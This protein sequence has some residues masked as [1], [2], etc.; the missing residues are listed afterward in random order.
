MRAKSWLVVGVTLLS[1]TV[2]AGVGIFWWNDAEW[3][4]VGKEAAGAE[5]GANPQ[6]VTPP[7]PVTTAKVRLGDAA[8]V[9]RVTGELVASRRFTV[10]APVAGTLLRLPARTGDRLRRGDL[11]GEIDAAPYALAVREAEAA[12]AV[13]AAEVRAAAARAEVA[14]RG[15]DRLSRLAPEL[16]SEAAIDRVEAEA[17]AREGELAV[18]GAR[19]K[20]AE[21]ARDAA[22]FN[23]R[24][25]RLMV[26][27]Q[28][29]DA[30]RAAVEPAA[31]PQAAEQVYTVVER[32]AEAGDRVGVGGGVVRLARTDPLTAELRGDPALAG[33]LAPGDMV[34]IR[35]DGGGTLPEASV[36]A[37]APVLDR[38]TRR[39]LIEASVP[40][41]QGLLK[42][43]AF[44]TAEVTT[45]RAADVLLVPADALVEPTDG[46]GPRIYRFT[47]G[48]A[49]AV[50][51]RRGLPG[52][53][54]DGETRPLVEV[55]S[56]DGRTLRA[57]DEIVV[58]G[59][60]LVSDGA[61][62]RRGSLGEHPPQPE[63]TP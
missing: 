28:A 24:R 26:D 59:A 40:N 10:A 56:I 12:V 18:A 60:H 44:I 52:V 16:R 21:A 50:T 7:L 32:L 53:L 17:A 8:E 41:P 61:L 42:P 9:T 58:L 34:T 31:A 54:L 1:L 15:V 19:L 22:A 25:T 36:T 55:E 37:I 5:S 38:A 46:Q 6:A 2:L 57:G 13:A 43:N 47:D 23:L 62:L 3:P 39:L 4:G 29:P 14:R 45:H 11:I 63:G 20:R 27:D 33:V 48:V 51:V 35:V 30:D 49:E